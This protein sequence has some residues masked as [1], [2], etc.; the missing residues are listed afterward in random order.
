MKLKRSPGYIHIY[1]LMSG[2][3]DAYTIHQVTPAPPSRVCVYTQKVH[4]FPT[5][6]R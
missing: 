1:S 5:V 2:S 6:C 4:N 3:Q